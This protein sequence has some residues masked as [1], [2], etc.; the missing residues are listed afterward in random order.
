MVK[1]GSGN[2][3]GPNVRS[4]FRWKPALQAEEHLKAAT[5]KPKC[6]SSSLPSELSAAEALRSYCV[7]N[8]RDVRVDYSLRLG[9][10]CKCPVRLKIT[11][12][13]FPTSSSPAFCF[14]PVRSSSFAVKVGFWSCK[15]FEI[16]PAAWLA[17]AL[18]VGREGWGWVVITDCCAGGEQGRLRELQY[19]G[20]KDATSLWDVRDNKRRVGSS[21]H[22]HNTNT[23]RPPTWNE[24]LVWRQRR[25]QR[26]RQDRTLTLVM[27]GMSELEHQGIY[28]PPGRVLPWKPS[29]TI[30]TQ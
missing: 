24:M 25:Q 1:N 3:P 15:S 4:L 9:L 29:I 18:G 10:Q 8:D 27:S 11:M 6:G 23:Q 20:W 26:T 17:V 19:G 13:P 30:P 12:K 2:P 5:Q 16:M 14:P 21:N 22:R 28:P 7:I